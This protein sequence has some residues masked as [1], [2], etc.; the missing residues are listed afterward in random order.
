MTALAVQESPAFSGASSATAPPYTSGVATPTATLA[1]SAVASSQS[2]AVATSSGAAVPMKTG[3]VGAAALFGGCG[4]G[5]E[6]LKK[7]VQISDVNSWLM[8][9]A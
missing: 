6:Y 8:E 9:L 7:E 5:H 1:T 4:I 2:A 3:A